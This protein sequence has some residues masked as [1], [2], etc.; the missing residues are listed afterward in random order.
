MFS[1]RSFIVSGLTFRSSFYFCVWCQKVFQF[2]SF[3]SGKPV[4]PAPL[5]TEIVFSPLDI[6]ASF[7]KDKVSIVKSLSHIRLFATPGSSLCGILQARILEWV[8]ISFFRIFSC[9]LKRQLQCIQE[10]WKLPY[11]S[12]MLFSVFS[13][14]FLFIFQLD[15]FYQAVF[16]FTNSVFCCVEHFVELISDIVIASDI[17]CP[18][19]SQILIIQ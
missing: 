18:F 14:I 6:L 8:A 5:V 17:E 10:L 11:M 7:V 15:I 16:Q 2:H 3:T 4:F 1:S 12:L 13:I 19:I 9:F